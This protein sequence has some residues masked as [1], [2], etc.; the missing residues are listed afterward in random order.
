MAEPYIGTWN[1]AEYELSGLA[2]AYSWDCGLYCGEIARRISP[3]LYWT[4][5]KKGRR[6]DI[7]FGHVILIGDEGS[8]PINP[9]RTILNIA[10]RMFWKQLDEHALREFVERITE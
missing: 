10:A 2:L 6:D 5:N 9:E 7:N 8:L 3:R 1:A 4:Q